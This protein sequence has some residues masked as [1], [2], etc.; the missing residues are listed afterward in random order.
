MQKFTSSQQ[1]LPGDVVGTGMFTK[2]LNAN[3]IFD[4]MIFGSGEHYVFNFAINLYWM[5]FLKITNQL[6]D[7]TLMNTLDGMNVGQYNVTSN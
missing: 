7:S 6:S 1:F 2:Y 5:R 3:N 4:K